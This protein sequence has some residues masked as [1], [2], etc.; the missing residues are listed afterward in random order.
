MADPAVLPT[1]F[2]A[3]R[4]ST[5]RCRIPNRSIVRGVR[6]AG[7]A[8]SEYML[9]VVEQESSQREAGAESLKEQVEGHKAFAVGLR[10]RG[11]YRDAERLRPVSEAKR[12]RMKPSGEVEVKFGPFGKDEGALAGYYLIEAASLDEATRI[13]N[14]CPLLPGDAIDVR[15]VMKSHMRSDKSDQPGK[16][17]AFAVLGS[18]PNEKAW[19]A[20]MD[21]IDAETSQDFPEDTFLGGLRLE[22]PKTGKRVVAEKGRRAL[23]DGPFLESKEVIGGIC[24]MRMRTLDDAVRWAR[25]TAFVKYGALEIRELWRS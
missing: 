15:P 10:A 5:D 23:F 4:K 17:F 8:M 3:A 16:V 21:R 20:T 13:A 18:E 22:A 2:C 12:V 11:A 6:K 19:I 1:D 7:S 25:N 14:E 24:F 9:M